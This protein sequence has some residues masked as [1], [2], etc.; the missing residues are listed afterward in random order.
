[1]TAGGLVEEN[2]KLKAEVERLR[3]LVDVAGREQQAAIDGQERAE[4]K[5]DAALAEIDKR[6]ERTRSW[7]DVRTHDERN[8]LRAIR[9]ALTDGRE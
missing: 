6:L 8:A 2:K 5:I 7:S 3:R 9:E 1:M 4:A